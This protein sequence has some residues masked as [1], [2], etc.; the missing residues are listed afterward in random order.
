MGNIC[1]AYAQY[2]WRYVYSQ[3]NLVNKQKKGKSLP[4]L[5]QPCRNQGPAFQLDDPDPVTPTCCSWGGI[6]PPSPGT[7]RTQVLLPDLSLSL[8]YL[9]LHDL[10]LWQI[11]HTNLRAAV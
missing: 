1:G 8:P 6:M 5:A 11:C 3:N 10:P 9:S 4:E 7:Y 2:L